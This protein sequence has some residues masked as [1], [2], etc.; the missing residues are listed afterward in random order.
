MFVYHFVQVE[1]PFAAVEA[2]VINAI[3]GFAGWATDAYREGENLRLKVGPG[4]HLAK[5]VLLH[6]VGEPT[7][8]PKETWI[9]IS[10]QATGVAGLFPRMEADIVVASVGPDLTQI[11]LRGSYLV[12]LGGVGRVLDGVL[13]HRIAEASVKAFVDRIADAVRANLEATHTSA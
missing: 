1:A 11:A 3:P 8:G 10:W 6:V 12:P 9:P 2:Q 5:E 4:A 7:R 13:L